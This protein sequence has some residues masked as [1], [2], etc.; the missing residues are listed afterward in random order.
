LESLNINLDEVKSYLED[1]NDKENTEPIP[2][3]QNL[4]SQLFSA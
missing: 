4:R 1:E 3:L 2:Q